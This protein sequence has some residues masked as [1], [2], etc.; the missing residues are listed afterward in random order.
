MNYVWNGTEWD[1]LG[2]T[3]AG[4][5]A[6]PE[7]GIPKSDLSADVQAS[8]TL[9]DTA[10]QFQLTE[11]DIKEEQPMKQERFNG[12]AQVSQVDNIN[13]VVDFK[14]LTELLGIGLLLTI[15]SSLSACIAIARFSPL[16]ILKERS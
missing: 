14:V 7:G 15:I 9:A 13:A 11:Q 4:G 1:A 10:I 3:V 8:L 12:I 16:T 2:S 6:K 5:Y